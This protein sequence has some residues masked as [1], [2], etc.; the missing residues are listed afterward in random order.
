MPLVQKKRKRVIKDDV[1]WEHRRRLVAEDGGHMGWTHDHFPGCNDKS[2]EVMDDDDGK[3]TR[4]TQ[5][6]LF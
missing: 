1:Y 2:V 5:T 3:K 6:S 4:T